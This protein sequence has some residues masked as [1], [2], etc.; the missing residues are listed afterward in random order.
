MDYLSWWLLS[1]FFLLA[2]FAFFGRR[3]LYTTEKDGAI[4]FTMIC[5]TPFVGEITVALFLLA[6]L[7]ITTYRILGRMIN[8]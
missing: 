8:L 2:A 4:I 5:L 7:F 6:V 1:R 3:L